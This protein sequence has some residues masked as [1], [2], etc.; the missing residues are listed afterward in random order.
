MKNDQA[1]AWIEKKQASFRERDHTGL[2]PLQGFTVETRLENCHS[3]PS[4]VLL[5]V[6]AEVKGMQRETTPAR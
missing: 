5:Q 1:S 3:L 4:R 6:K 2:H